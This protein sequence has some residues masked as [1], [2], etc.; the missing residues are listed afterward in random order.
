MPVVRCQAEP[1]R[2]REMV[3][4]EGSIESQAAEKMSR[5]PAE[6]E[7]QAQQK[8]SFRSLTYVLKW[9]L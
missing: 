4:T 9:L 5:Q 1:I 8:N 2:Y 6:I 7:S 3:L